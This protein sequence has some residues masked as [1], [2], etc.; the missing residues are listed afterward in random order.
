MRLLLIDHHAL[1]REGL[2]CFLENSLGDAGEILEA[3]NFFDGLKIAGEHAGLDLVLL[4][5]NSPGCDGVISVK[6][7]RK[8][9]PCVSVVVVSIEED[10]RVINRALQYGASAY[11]CK[12]EDGATLLDTLR[13]ACSNR[14]RLSAEPFRQIDMTGENIEARDIDRRSN[15]NEYGLTRRQMDILEC[16]AAG[17]TNKEISAATGLAGGTI[18]MHLTNMYQTLCVKNRTEAIRSAREIGLVDSIQFS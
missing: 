14:V 12:S 18:K 11:V 4:E 16:L 2:R 1:F 13:F 9:Y 8:Y 6:L 10:R 15:A 17:Y 3:G 5:I 7:F